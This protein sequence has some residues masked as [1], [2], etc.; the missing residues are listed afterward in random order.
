MGPGHWPSSLSHVS[1]GTLP[2]PLPVSLRAGPS[3]TGSDAAAPR[4]TAESCC[5]GAA[6]VAWATHRTAQKPTLETPRKARGVHVTLWL[7]VGAS[8]GTSAC[9]W[10][11]LANMP[12]PLRA[13]HLLL[14]VPS[15]ECRGCLGSLSFL[16]PGRV[17]GG[18]SWTGRRSWS[19]ADK[20]PPGLAGRPA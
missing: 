4:P 8:T 6:G 16:P 12:S 15:C 18:A 10:A 11:L 17:L 3:G 20:S 19:V 1:P 9:L 2:C 5:R 7:R 13:G 14:A